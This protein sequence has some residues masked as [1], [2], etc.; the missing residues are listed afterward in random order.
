MIE[1][2]FSNVNEY[3]PRS[4]VF[5]NQLTID[6]CKRSWQNLVDENI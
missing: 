1:K 6:D 3:S 4:F 2:V 5:E